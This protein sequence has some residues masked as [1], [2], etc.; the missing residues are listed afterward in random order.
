MEGLIRLEQGDSIVID[1]SKFDI[2]VK[3]HKMEE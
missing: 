1:V 3:Q 2:Y